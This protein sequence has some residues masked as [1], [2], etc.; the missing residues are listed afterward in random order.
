MNTIEILYE[1]K[2][3]NNH[4]FDRKLTINSK[5]TLINGVKKIGLSALRI[6]GAFHSLGNALADEIENNNNKDNSKTFLP[7]GV[8]I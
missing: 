2:H 4:Y 3:K 5:K 7:I 1:I 6:G 8:R